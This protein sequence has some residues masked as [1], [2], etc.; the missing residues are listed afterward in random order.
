MNPNLIALAFKLADSVA[1][2]D[3][4]LYCDNTRTD[5]TPGQPGVRRWY[6]TTRIDDV[7]PPEDIADALSYLHQ[8]G[9]LIRD[10]AQPTLVTFPPIGAGLHTQDAAA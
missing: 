4:E 3:I 10:P 5:G 1:R 7:C 9:L 6:D 2:S 8:R